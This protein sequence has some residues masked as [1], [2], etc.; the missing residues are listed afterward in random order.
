MTGKM[1]DG[2][3]DNVIFFVFLFCRLFKKIIFFQECVNEIGS[4]YKPWFFKHV[5]SFLIAQTNGEEF[6]PLQ[7]YYFR[8]NN[9]LFWEIQVKKLIYH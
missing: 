6:I 7:D 4:F 1:T 2:E 8:H 5:E 9:S 3:K